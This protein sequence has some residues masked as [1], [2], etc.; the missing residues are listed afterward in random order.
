MKQITLTNEELKI[1]TKP[2]VSST[3]VP[4]FF[5]HAITEQ[6][7]PKYQKLWDKILNASQVNSDLVDR[8]IRLLPKQGVDIEKDHSLQSYNCFTAALHVLKIKGF[9]PAIG[10]FF[11]ESGMINVPMAG[12]S[13]FDREGLKKLGFKQ[14]PKIRENR[15]KGLIL[16][17]NSM[18]QR[19]NHAAAYLGT[20]NDMD[21]YFH[22]PLPC[23]PDIKPL[24]TILEASAYA[25][26]RRKRAKVT[27]TYW[28]KTR[29]K[30]KYSAKELTPLVYNDPASGQKDKALV[31]PRAEIYKGHDLTSI[32]LY[33]DNTSV[34]IVEKC[35]YNLS[36][37]GLSITVR[38]PD[39]RFGE[40]H[41]DPEHGDWPRVREMSKDRLQG[42]IECNPH[43]LLAADILG[44]NRQEVENILNQKGMFAYHA[45]A[46]RKNLFKN[47]RALLENKYR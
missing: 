21:F 29:S 31:D 33:Q 23:V 40:W 27:Y 22:K 10:F 15:S 46:A 2:E 39:G 7:F 19:Y 5:P 4:I 14:V 8:V 35:L 1:L 32:V 44:K 41:E 12:L 11:P 45:Q 37:V 36:G 28:Q 30:K 17:E 25:G 9:E 3:G 24:E 34:G 6:D 26:G 18:G 13:F 38:T 16:L 43:S 20:A 47:P 42:L